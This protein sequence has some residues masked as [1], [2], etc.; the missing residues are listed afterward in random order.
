VSHP[1]ILISHISEGCVQIADFSVNRMFPHFE[2]VLDQLKD[3]QKSIT[4]TTLIILLRSMKSKHAESFCIQKLTT[5]N[6]EDEKEVPPEHRQEEGKK[7]PPQEK[8]QNEGEILDL[9]GEL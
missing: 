9:I 5:E 1:V 8:P 6:E 7:K 4:L 3:E 2:P